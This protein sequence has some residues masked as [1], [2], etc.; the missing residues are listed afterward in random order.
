MA[1]A[2]FDFRGGHVY[3]NGIRISS[4]LSAVCLQIGSAVSTKSRLRAGRSGGLIPASQ[5]KKTE[6]GSTCSTYGGEERCIQG[7]SGES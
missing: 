1:V 3:C 5:V 2:G 6:M 4:S 7:F